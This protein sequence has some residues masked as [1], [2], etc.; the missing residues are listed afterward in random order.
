MSGRHTVVHRCQCVSMNP[1]MQIMPRPSSAAAPGAASVCATATIAPSRTCT[2]PRSKSPS[3]ASMV[4]TVA[5]RTTNSPRAG[6]GFAAGL[7]LD[8]WPNARTGTIAAAATPIATLRRAR[9]FSR[10]VSI[11]VEC[12]PGSEFSPDSQVAGGPAGLI[13]APRDSGA[14]LQPDQVADAQLRDEL[15]AYA[16]VIVG[17]GVVLPRGADV[18][19]E[20]Q[21]EPV[22]PDR[23]HHQVPIDV[24]NRGSPFDRRDARAVPGERRLAAAVA[25]QRELALVEDR[26][27]ELVVREAA[28]EL[29]R[30]GLVLAVRF[31]PA[32]GE[33]RLAER[34][35][36]A[37]VRPVDVAGE[38]A[39]QTVRGFGEELQPQAL[40]RPFG[41]PALAAGVEPADQPEHALVL[42]RCVEAHL[43]EAVALERA[44]E[45]PIESTI[46]GQRT[47]GGDPLRSFLDAVGGDLV[48]VVLSLDR[49]IA[50]HEQ[51]VACVVGV[52][53]VRQGLV[54][55]ELVP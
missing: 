23:G 32:Q 40:A 49:Q 38:G 17:P 20:I 1:G 2:S 21:R 50:A 18:D 28:A 29:K 55:G 12:L 44:A 52:F 25:A 36:A 46:E 26:Q 34:D 39:A 31:V 27:D 33:D 24:A 48:V 35:V 6:N 43:M 14:G 41:E 19:E 53:E 47:P 54:L 42:E 13:D 15:G 8:A 10:C 22:Q 4:S 45:A 30:L 37:P 9:R 7:A 11:L 51:A 3:F 16:A 5:P